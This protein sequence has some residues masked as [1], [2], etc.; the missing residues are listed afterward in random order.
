VTAHEK[1]VRVRIPELMAIEGLACQVRGLNRTENA[2]RLDD[3]LTEEVAEY[4]TSGA[5]EELVDVVEVVRAITEQ[6]G[7]PWD[8]F[9][10]R[11]LAKRRERG[12]FEQRFRLT[13]SS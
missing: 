5:I 7:M 2:A 9:E 8:E 3:K 10:A 12:G 13:R 4:R 11:R 6:R 1:L